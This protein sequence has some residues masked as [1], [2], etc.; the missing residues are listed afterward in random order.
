ML[1]QLLKYIKSIFF[2]ECL[3]GFRMFIIL[4]IFL[5]LLTHIT[6]LLF[7]FKVNKLSL[8][9]E[10]SIIRQL[11]YTLWEYLPLHIRYLP[12]LLILFQYIVPFLN[13]IMYENWIDFKVLL[14]VANRI[15]DNIEQLPQESN[16]EV[17][18]GRVVF[19]EFDLYLI[20]NSFWEF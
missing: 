6:D 8:Q 10:Q 2:N 9:E 3:I 15:D 7:L 13:I 18:T 19:L 1:Y 4:A 20:F 17:I 12:I 14:Q 11:N 5:L 16:S